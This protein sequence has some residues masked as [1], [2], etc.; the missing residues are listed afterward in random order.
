MHVP[1][2]FA[3]KAHEAYSA[4]T[5]ANYKGTGSKLHGV[6]EY[7][8]E[9]RTCT[10][11]VLCGKP[12]KLEVHTWKLIPLARY[13]KGRT[14]TYLEMANRVY[15][16]EFDGPSARFT[17]EGM[18]VNYRGK[19]YVLSEQITLVADPKAPGVAE[20]PPKT[21]KVTAALDFWGS[22]KKGRK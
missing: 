20:A 5:I 2:G 22:A 6:F 10:G 19:K 4:D 17:Y 9:L 21:G 3:E 14:Y 8:G 1:I 12:Y 18:I 7:R 13:T 16:P 15:D 11:A